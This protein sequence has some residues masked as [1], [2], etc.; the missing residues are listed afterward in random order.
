MGKA[1]FFSSRVLIVVWVYKSSHKILG[2][3]FD[4]KS[5]SVSQEIAVKELIFNNVTIY[6]L[7]LV[8]I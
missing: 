4:I 2:K 3:R 5:L 6:R 8:S 1:D 7:N